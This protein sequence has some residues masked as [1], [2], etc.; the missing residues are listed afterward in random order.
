MNELQIE[1]SSTLKTWLFTN[2]NIS[3]NDYHYFFLRCFKLKKRFNQSWTNIL[4]PL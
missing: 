3:I 1:L 2:F 4:L